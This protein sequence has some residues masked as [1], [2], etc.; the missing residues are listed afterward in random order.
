MESNITDDQHNKNKKNTDIIENKNGN[1]SVLVKKVDSLEKHKEDLTEQNN[2]LLIRLNQAKTIIKNNEYIDTEVSYKAH[3][4]N[5]MQ[6]NSVVKYIRNNVFPDVKVV[7]N[8][9]L[10]EHPAIL[11]DIFK[12]LQMPKLAEQVL[13]K[14]DVIHWLKHTLTQKRRYIKNRLKEAVK[15]KSV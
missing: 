4:L 1:D 3:K 11:E 14:D 15:S 5:K 13:Y 9:F 12:H 8:D 6:V 10:K 7:N 2:T